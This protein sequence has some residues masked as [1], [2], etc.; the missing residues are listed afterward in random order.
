MSTS[1]PPYRFLSHF[2]NQSFVCIGCSH[3][4][5]CDIN[6]FVIRTLHYGCAQ[7]MYGIIAQ[8]LTWYQ[9]NGSSIDARPKF[10]TL[11]RLKM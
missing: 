11:K 7:M 6:A 9:Q 1:R 10:E 8:W 2:N 3:D 4:L 5:M